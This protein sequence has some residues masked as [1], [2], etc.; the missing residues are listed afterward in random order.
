MSMAEAREL[1]ET[2]GVSMRSAF[3]KLALI[4]GYT[5]PSTCPHSRK[6]SAEELQQVMDERGISLSQAYRI[7]RKRKFGNKKKEIEFGNNVK[8]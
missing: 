6:F 2:Y 8:I 4:R 1:A 3:R 7:L 5:Y